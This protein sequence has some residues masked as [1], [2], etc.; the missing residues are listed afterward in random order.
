MT[1][2]ELDEKPL[3]FEERRPNGMMA[4]RAV[5]RA[6]SIKERAKQRD[7]DIERMWTMM[8]LSTKAFTECIDKILDKEVTILEV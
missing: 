2:I 7:N 4:E 3:A 5:E 8:E 1:R 6:E